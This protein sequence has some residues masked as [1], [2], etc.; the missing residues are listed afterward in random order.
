MAQFQEENLWLH[1]LVARLQRAAATGPR[2]SRQISSPWAT[3]VSGSGGDADRQAGLLGEEAVEPPQQ[4]AAAAKHQAV[5]DQVGGQ[6]GTALVERGLDGLEDR[7]QRIGQGLADLFAGDGRLAGQAADGVQA[8]DL[9]DPFFFQRVGAADVD[10]QPLGGG[11]ADPQA[12]VAAEV[13]DDRPG[14]W[15]R[16]RC[17]RTG[18]PRCRPG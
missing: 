18:R 3:A 7:L 15:R 8:A 4:R 5:V 1:V 14:P 13:I 11:Q 6:V 12:V 17:G 9:V 16:R 10:P 2:C